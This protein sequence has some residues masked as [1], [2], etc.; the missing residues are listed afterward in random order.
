MFKEVEETLERMQDFS[1]K[2][3]LT[4]S[5]KDARQVVRLFTDLSAKLDEHKKSILNQPL[6]V[7]SGLS[8]I[9][10]S[11]NKICRCHVDIADLSVPMY[12]IVR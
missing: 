7:F 10:L 9:L 2:A 4:K 11:I 1:V 3:F 8:S 5:T 12:P 6:E